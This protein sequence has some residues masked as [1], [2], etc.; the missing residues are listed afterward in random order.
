MLY[1]GIKLMQNIMNSIVATLKG[2][3]TGCEIISAIHEI[4]R[5]ISE[6][7]STERHFF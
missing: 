7:I 1:S 5:A 3:T 2:T 6:I 4:E